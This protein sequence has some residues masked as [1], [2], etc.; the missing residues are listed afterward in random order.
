MDR[1]EIVLRVGGRPAWRFEEG[2]GTKW[3]PR[4][5]DRQSDP[6]GAE[7]ARVADWARATAERNKL[8]RMRDGRAVYIGAERVD[9][10]TSHPAFRAGASTIADLYDLKADP[11]QRDLFSFEEDG[12]RYQPLLA[13]LPHPRRSRS[14]H[15]R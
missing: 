2:E 12:E 14:P 3:Q 4:P 7:V 11:A 10:V 6:A 13:A 8:E 9:D 15:A 5:A 1:G